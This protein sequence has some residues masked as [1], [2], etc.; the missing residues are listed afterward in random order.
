MTFTSTKDA[1][2]GLKVPKDLEGLQARKLPPHTHFNSALPNGYFCFQLVEFFVCFFCKSS[3]PLSCLYIGMFCIFFSA[4]P[5]SHFVF[6]PVLF[7]FCL[8]FFCSVCE[9]QL[10]QGLHE[11]LPGPHKRR[12]LFA[13]PVISLLKKTE[14]FS[15][16]ADPSSWPKKN[17][18]R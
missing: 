18:S 12:N 13:R 9:E 2:I 15:L 7:L 8:A 11:L 10:A 6:L 16:E 4:L 5:K 14:I 3:P 17:G 1:A